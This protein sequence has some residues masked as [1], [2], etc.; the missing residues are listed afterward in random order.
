M[1]QPAFLSLIREK[2]WPVK[3]SQLSKAKSAKLYTFIHCLSIEVLQSEEKLESSGTDFIFS[4]FEMFGR[5]DAARD[6]HQTISK[7]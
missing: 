7:A 4:V 1:D 5:D 3:N 6:I 2:D